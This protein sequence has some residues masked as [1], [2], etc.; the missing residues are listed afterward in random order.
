MTRRKLWTKIFSLN[1]TPGENSPNHHFSELL[2]EE[3][4]PSGEPNTVINAVTMYKSCLDTRTI[5]QLASA[6]IIEMVNMHGGWPMINPNWNSNRYN[7]MDVVGKLSQ[8]GV[9]VFINSQVVPSFEDSTMNVMMVS[10][11]R[12]V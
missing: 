9:G 2:E 5:E 8:L 7:I 10:N 6:P 4:F 1:K 12:E 3:T 11:H